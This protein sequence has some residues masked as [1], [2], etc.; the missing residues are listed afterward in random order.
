ME[1]KDGASVKI[2]VAQYKDLTTVSLEDGASGGTITF[3]DAMG[4]GDGVSLALS[5]DID[6]VLASGDNYFTVSGVLS[7][8]ISSDGSLYVTADGSTAVNLGAIVGG[9][10]TGDAKPYTGSTG[11]LEATN[12]KYT[13]NAGGGSV[14]VNA[15]ESA[16]IVGRAGGDT[17]M[18]K[19][20]V[21]AGSTATFDVTLGSGADNAYLSWGETLAGKVIVILRPDKKLHFLEC[22]P[23]P[24]SPRISPSHQAALPVCSDDLGLLRIIPSNSCTFSP[25]SVSISAL[26][27]V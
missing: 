6:Y 20:D 4:S 3:A 21:A 26:R 25:I 7:G 13:A 16:T 2:N 14:L 18:F 1:L 22:C 24:L 15:S 10:V 8:S 9:S 12:V 11:G 5:D 27:S 17:F 23:D 19:S